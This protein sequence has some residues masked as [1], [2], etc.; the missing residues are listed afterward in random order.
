MKN[1]NYDLIL[2]SINLSISPDLSTFFGQNNLANFYNDE[3]NNLLSEVKNTVDDNKIKQ[4]YRR[5]GEIY[6]NEVPYISLYNNKY[7]VAYNKNLVGTV[8]ANWYYQFY[9]IHD[10]YK[11]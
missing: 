6:I 3:V 2:C 8:E 9:N 10:W 4:N 11:K 1:K 7:T 5:L